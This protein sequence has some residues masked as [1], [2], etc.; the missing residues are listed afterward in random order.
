MVMV[1][2]NAPS[3]LGAKKRKRKRTKKKSKAVK[4]LTNLYFGKG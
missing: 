3:L 4:K 2:A 1:R